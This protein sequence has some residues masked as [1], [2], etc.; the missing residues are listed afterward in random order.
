MRNFRKALALLLVFAALICLTA[1]GEDTTPD[2]LDDV[3]D[4]GASKDDIA[5]SSEEDPAPAEGQTAMPVAVQVFNSTQTT[6]AILGT[7]EEGATVTASIVGGSKAT[8]NANGKIFALEIDVGTRS[9][10]HIQLTATAPD[11]TESDPKVV[12]GG[13][14]AIAEGN[15]VYPTVLADEVTL[16]LKSSLEVL[17]EDA[18]RTNTAIDTFTD[19]IDVYVD[20]LAKLGDTELIYVLM[21]SKVSGMSDKLPEG[22][23][24][25]D[26]VTLY[27]QAVAAINASGATLIDVKAAL[28]D[29]ELED[30]PLYYRTHSAWSEY[31]AYLAYC[32]LMNYIA[33]KYP[34]AAP[35]SLDE[36][37]LKTV[38]DALGGDLA[39]H[40]GLNA[41]LVRETVY[42]LVPKFD[43][44][45][46]DSIPENI[47]VEKKLL[48]SN[49]KQY[50]AE[51][52]Y[53]FYDSYFASKQIYQ[54]PNYTLVDDTFGFYTGRDELPTAFIYRDEATYGAIDMLAERFNNCMF[55][56]AGVYTVNTSKA[57]KYAAEGKTNVD[58]IIVMI[59]EDN[60]A[61][62][63]ANNA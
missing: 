60:L 13:Y 4:L 61:S 35:R 18:V 47:E 33:E 45:I 11:K 9:E 54:D 5:S 36:F 63:I 17:S 7:C 31:G 23:D 27:D 41:E 6:V 21:P 10:A 50:V 1:C 43:V 19:K 44:A 57:S 25:T 29:K 26:G 22:T 53:K 32:E 62:L 48:I 2:I 49:I 58:Y 20:T 16:F 51:D 24:V 55:E 28:A 37:E 15:L 8:V 12:V 40:F 14:N 39:Y 3:P 56:K 52:D 59:S 38:E 34:A 42:D 30:I 46:G